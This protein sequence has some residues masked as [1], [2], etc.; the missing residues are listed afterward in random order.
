MTFKSFAPPIELFFLT[1]GQNNFGSFLKK[2][3]TEKKSIENSGSNQI[4][5]PSGTEV[6]LIPS[7]PLGTFAY[8]YG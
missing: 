2:L 6:L 4:P 3:I 8:A 5:I 7:F 1:V